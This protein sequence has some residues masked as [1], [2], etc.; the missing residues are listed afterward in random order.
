MGRDLGIWEPSLGA[1]CSG[2]NLLAS[3]MPIGGREMERV[4]AKQGTCGA[5][6]ERG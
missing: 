5:E 4:K 1:S 2:E 6:I 3:E